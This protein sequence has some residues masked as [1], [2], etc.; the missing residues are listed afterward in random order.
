MKSRFSLALLALAAALAG[1]PLRIS[2]F[3]VDVT[4]PL[5]SPLCCSAGVKA[6]AKIIDPLSARGII[7][8][9][10]PKP[11]VLVAVDWEGIANEGWD[12]WRQALAAAAHT[13]IDHVSVHTL[14]QHDAPGYDATAQR[15]LK[16]YGLGSQ[17]YHPDFMRAAIKRVAASAREALGKAETVTHLGLGRAKVID[18]ASNRRVLG[19]DG[20][21][22]YV[23]FSASRI[24]EAREAPE[25][26]IDPYVRVVSFWN[27]DRPLVCI[28][29]YATHPQSYYGQG[30]VSADFVGMARNIRE[31]EVPVPHIHFNGAG[32]NVAA[33]K[34]NDGSPQNRLLL[35]LRLADGMRAAWNS[36][37]KTPISASDVDWRSVPVMLPVAEPIRDQSRLEALVADKSQPTRARLTAA[38]DLAFTRLSGAK[39]QIPV[40][41]LTLGPAR[42]VH[43][44]GEL[45]IEY[46]LAAQDR[47]PGAFVAMAAYGD[48]GP[49]YIG[50]RIAYSQGGYET[51][52]VSRT[53]PDVEEVLMSALRALLPDSR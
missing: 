40:S 16:K 50:T 29:Y 32:G 47:M 30:G 43:M 37:V 18:V 9:G 20:K 15:T 4:P 5:G 38:R 52:P 23:R 45:F 8:L 46:Q 3:Q 28:T 22:K 42:I 1:Q 7:L 14:H 6:A 25:G 24:A 13:D 19:P 36:M 49:G 11:I 34:Y 10:P 31:A 2:T 27:G 53:S 48:Y 26:L 21:V 35:A 17:L 44:P 12:D 41:L 51:G 33:G 39:R